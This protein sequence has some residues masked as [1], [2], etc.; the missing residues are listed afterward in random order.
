MNTKVD[1]LAKNVEL[2]R[3]DMKL[4]RE[5]L[6]TILGV[7][8]TNITYIEQ[9]KTPKPGWPIIR[10]LADLFGVASGK[11]LENTLIQT[12]DRRQQAINRIINNL[13]ESEW[14]SIIAQV[15][16]FTDQ[17]CAVGRFRSQNRQEQ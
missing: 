9:A 14:M 16:G 8:V 15:N 11:E 10:D 13:N 4:S 3:K 12:I 7:S 5:E 17:Q 6:A 2:F 1:N